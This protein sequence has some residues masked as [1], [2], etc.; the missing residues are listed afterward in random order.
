[1]QSIKIS[2]IGRGRVGTHLHSAFKNIGA[3][4]DIQ[5]QLVDSR[6]FDG[7]WNNSDLY[8]ITVSDNAISD[9]SSRLQSYNGIVAHTSGTTPLSALTT[10]CTNCGV[11][12][13]MQTFSANRELDYSRIPIFI[14]ANN[15]TNESLLFEIAQLISDNVIKCNSERRQSLHIAA[16]LACN[17]TNH[18]YSL[19]AEYLENNG[20]DFSVM[21][22]LIEESVAKL[23]NLSPQDAQTGPAI[24]NDSKTI[25]AHLQALDNQPN[26]KQIYSLLTSS[27]QNNEVV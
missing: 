14:E 20:F 16:V 26:L 5:V 11:F 7:L 23:H 25:N 22:P 18:L 8:L 17:F 15:T 21:L 6:T 1:M 3:D 27:I 12:Y 10:G 24:R 13:P 2:I 4:K 19:S 9:V